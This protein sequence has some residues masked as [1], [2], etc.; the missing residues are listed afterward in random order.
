MP[1]TILQPTIFHE[2]WWLNAA[3]N[4]NYQVVESSDGGGVVGRMPFYMRRR[5]GMNWCVMPLL[6]Y[7]LGPAIDVGQG[8]DR[9]HLSH[10]LE[11]TRDL[12]Q[13]LP[14]ASFMQIKCHRD[15][16]DVLAFQEQNFR[17]SVQFTHEIHPASE[18]TLWNNL[19]RS[20][21]KE[22]VK[23]QKNIA[24]DIMDDPAAFLQFYE[25]NLK[26]K[27]IKAYVNITDCL[28]VMAT[29]ISKQRGQILG[30]KDKNGIL[31]AAIFYVWDD[32]SVYGLLTTRLPTADNGT[33]SAL[34]W[35]AILEASKRNLIFDFAG[36]ATKGS[37]MFYAGFG[38]IIKPRYVAT[39][40]S[41]PVQMAQVILRSSDKNWFL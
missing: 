8:T 32:T 21:R 22:I 31:N 12:I 35:Q 36:L 39:K 30:A 17:T 9:T 6:T 11:I 19:R 29:A 14:P 27:N 38:C 1:N 40:A 26:V 13:K 33:V 4:G 15:V 34:V 41:L 5:M 37:I 28:K 16:N 23:A 18:E 2:E 25:T 7:F 10:Q 24:I 20:R 3:T